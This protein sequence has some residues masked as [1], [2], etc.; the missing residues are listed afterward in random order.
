MT[1]HRLCLLHPADPRVDTGDPVE[2]RIATVVASR[3]TDFELVWVGIDRR[4]DLEPGVPVEIEV[5]GRSLVFLPVADR[6]GGAFAAGILRR[7]P[8][9][10]AAARAELSSPAV[11]DLAW[12]PFAPLIG[13]PIVLVIHRDPR[14]GA[15]AG[16]VSFRVALRERLALRLA[17]RIVA[18]DAQFVRR[19]R[20]ARPA[21]A[22]KTEWLPLIGSQI[23][24]GLA[25]VGDETRIARLWERHRRLY[26]AHAAHR[27]SQIAA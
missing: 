5:G 13:R 18:C 23:P 25:A 4:G 17:D 1:R 24:G 26:D 27:A 12:V 8:A 16:R 7:L 9:I 11:H 2:A 19:C 20:D 21:L 10:R 22:A 6:D 15:V 3:P 14:A